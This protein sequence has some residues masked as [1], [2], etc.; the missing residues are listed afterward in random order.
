MKAKHIII[1]SAALL[2]SAS[3]FCQPPKTKIGVFLTTDQ[4][5]TWKPASKGL[6]LDADI[7]AWLVTRN[8]TIL[9]TTLNYGVFKS[10][11]GKSWDRSSAGLPKDILTSTIIVH[12]NTLL[13]G[14]YGRGVYSSKDQGKTWKASSTGLNTMNIHCFYSQDNLFFAGTDKGIYTSENG[15]E[16]WKHVTG[17]MQI[18]D[19]NETDGVLFANTNL[20]ALRS[21]NH[22]STWEGAPSENAYAQASDS[23]QVSP[24]SERN[25]ALSQADDKKW[26]MPDLQLSS[27]TFRI[28]PVS[29][30]ILLAPWKNVF[31]PLRENRPFQN[32]GLPADMSFNKI[33]VTPFGILV[34]H[35]NSGC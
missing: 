13:I 1:L 24:L 22:G 35:E 20:G 17:S 10:S 31:R 28:T 11:D 9:M 5:E 14:S 7:S 2:F 16:S 4:G 26:F 27:Y 29:A 15:G 19:F 25:R 33:L 30:P 21:E 6:P 12:D 34:A 3:G 32:T 8:N 23:V 18:N